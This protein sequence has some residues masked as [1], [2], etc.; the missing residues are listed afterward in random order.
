MY[1]GANPK[2]SSVWTPTYFYVTPKAGVLFVGQ[3]SSQCNGKD[4]QYSLALVAI[5]SSRC[6]EQMR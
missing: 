1:F 3:F 5:K 2:Q 6:S 4:H